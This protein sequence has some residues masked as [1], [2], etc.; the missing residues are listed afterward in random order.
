MIFTLTMNPCLDR[1]LYVDELKSDDTIRVKE[2]KDYPAGKA[3][4]QG[5]HRG[6]LHHRCRSAGEGTLS[7]GRCYHN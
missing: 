7:R 6:L 5:R 4:A 2:I 1:F 3:T